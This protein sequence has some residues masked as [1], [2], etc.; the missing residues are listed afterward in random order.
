LHE[1]IASRSFTGGKLDFGSVSSMRP[2]TETHFQN[3][4]QIRSFPS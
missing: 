4:S 2:S 3:S 1:T